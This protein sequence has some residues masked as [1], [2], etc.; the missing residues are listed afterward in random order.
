MCIPSPPHTFW[1]TTRS[2]RVRS[3]RDSATVRGVK[4]TH[5]PALPHYAA[6]NCHPRHAAIRRYD[7]FGPSRP[8]LPE[9]K[10]ELAM[11]LPARFWEA[12]QQEQRMVHD[13]GQ[14]DN[15]H[16]MK[17]LG[18]CGFNRRGASSCCW[19]WSGCCCAISSNNN[20]A[21]SLEQVLLSDSIA[22]HHTPHTTHT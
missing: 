1:A 15:F 19:F 9:Y 18:S 13:I 22:P 3:V 17:V 5:T 21:Y 16:V 11:N 12:A 2:P 14:W 7:R 20:T 10:W 4:N 8:P 6:I